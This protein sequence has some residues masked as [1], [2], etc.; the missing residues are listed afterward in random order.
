[1]IIEK[2]LCFS[3]YGVKNM[4]YVS[5]KLTFIGNPENISTSTDQ[6]VIAVE[7][8]TEEN[9]KSSLSHQKKDIVSVKVPSRDRTPATSRSSSRCSGRFIIEDRVVP[10][11]ISRPQTPEKDGGI[12]DSNET[13]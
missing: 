9:K 6:K 2:L 13:S 1:M 11:A 10:G 4:Q 12:A 7:D 5:M 3:K 8:S